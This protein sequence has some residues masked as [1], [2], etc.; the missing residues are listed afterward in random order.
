LWSEKPV[1]YLATRLDT[2]PG[3]KTVQP[4]ELSRSWDYAPKKNIQVICYTNLTEVELFCNGKSRGT[5]R[6][7]EDHE[8]ITWTIPFER[9]K[10]EV[11]GTA[12]AVDTLESTLPA[13]NL[14]LGEWKNA[15][16][17]K[18]PAQAGKYRITQIEAE[19][20]DEEG[21]LCPTADNL[22]HVSLT[23][24]GK[25]LGLENGDLSDCTEYAAPA[26]RAYRGRL[27]IYALVEGK[28]VSVTASAEGI[29]PAVIS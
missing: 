20:L 5:Q 6:R 23:G 18:Y 9:G 4:W 25:I 22:I 13:V 2:S 7:D 1:L 17:E 8:Y 10:L 3:E 21:R 12:A 28:G 11:R 14:R 27:I 26:R 16:G 15:C 29:P 19:L 24:P